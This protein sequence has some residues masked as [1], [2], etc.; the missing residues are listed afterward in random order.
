MK[1]E[2]CVACDAETPLNSLFRV[3]DRLLCESCGNRELGELRSR[4]VEPTVIRE[5]DPT[6]C[7]N[8]SADFGSQALPRVLDCP[9]CA[10]CTQLIYARPFPTW[11]KASFA[12]LVLALVFAIVHAVPYF[13]AGREYA[14]AERLFDAGKYD[15]AI[16]GL[17]AAV[18]AG[19]DA[20][21]IRLQL[22]FAYLAVADVGK[23]SE[24]V[25]DRSFPKSELFNR[26]QATFARFDK[27]GLKLEEAAKLSEQNRSAEA[28]KL[29]R[30]AAVLLP[31]LPDLA[32]GVEIMEASAAF[33]QKDYEGFIK[34][35]EKIWNEK[36]DS[37]SAAMLASAI[38]CRYATGGVAAE[39]KSAE[40]MLN[41]AGQLATTDE[42]REALAEYTPRIRHRLDSREIID[43]K[44]FNRRYRPELAE[45]SN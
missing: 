14:R 35:S 20:S 26:V 44:E 13:K 3:N 9:L 16:P 8:C 2:R 42:E 1:C 43:R 11:L 39:R 5:V 4:N 21:E 31:E 37:A 27:A 15:E 32:E 30:E 24:L 45:E 29:L 23:A 18:K 6:V 17:E 38:A 19:P 25:K 33:E 22:A 34:A 7:A 40:E 12:G 36:H 10:N 41:T 28:A